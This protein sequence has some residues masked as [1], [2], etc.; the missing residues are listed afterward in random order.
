MAGDGKTSK[1]AWYHIK[2]MKISSQHLDPSPF[3]MEISESSLMSTICSK[4]SLA[5]RDGLN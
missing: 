4:L 2:N 3:E 5:L 1:Q